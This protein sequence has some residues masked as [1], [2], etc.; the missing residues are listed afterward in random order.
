L[1]VSARE[2]YK[3]TCYSQVDSKKVD[4]QLDPLLHDDI[5]PAA[6]PA[7]ISKN[8]AN[9]QWLKIINKRFELIGMIDHTVWIC[10]LS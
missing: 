7:I 2:C 1:L 3:V 8:T 6:L 4:I 9:K 10:L 5:V